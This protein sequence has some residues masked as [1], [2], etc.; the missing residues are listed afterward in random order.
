M[1]SPLLKPG[2]TVGIVV[3]ARKADEQL[4]R[5]GCEVIES[6][7]LR[8]QFG[9]HCFHND[10]TYLAATDSERLMDFQSMIDNPEIDA[11][12]CARGGYGTTRILDQLNFES[13][14]AKPKWIVGFSDITALHIKLHQL[15]IESIHG[16]MPTQFSNSAYS[17]SVDSLKKMLFS[18]AQNAITVQAAKPNR[19]GSV[20]GNVI[21]GNLSLIVDSL[22]TST[23]IN[24]S[25]KILVVEEVDERLYKIDRMFTQLKRAGKL[26]DLAGLIVGHFTDLGDTELPFGQLYEDIILDKISAQSFP[27]AFGFPIGH[28]APNLAW[29]HGAVAS[30]NVSLEGALLMFD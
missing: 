6:W 24:T 28:Q 26:T 4:L 27:V 20:K 22:G 7:G 21:G 15:G 18:P 30:L 16:S 14:V 17:D 10:N 12:F 29:R 5:K 2:Q 25:G 11:I 13:F 8:V 1:R 9:A 19:I 23:E 3:P